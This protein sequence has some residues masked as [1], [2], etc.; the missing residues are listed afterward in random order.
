MANKKI[1]EKKI[2]AKERAKEQKKTQTRLFTARRARYEREMMR[3]SKEK[4]EKIEPIRNSSDLQR[5]EKNL[6]RNLEVLKALEEEYI[7]SQ[8]ARANLHEELAAEG[9]ATIEEKVEALKQKAVDYASQAQEDII[10]Y[11][12]ELHELANDADEKEKA[13]KPLTKRTKKITTID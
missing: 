2:K 12:A 11:E 7:A 9:Y 4:A 13:I 8:K 1:V 6:N 5:I 3:D 10:E